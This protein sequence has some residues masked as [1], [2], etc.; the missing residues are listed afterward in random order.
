[1]QK[2][3]RPRAAHCLSASCAK[4][5]LRAERYYANARHAL[6]RSYIAY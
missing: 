4:S 1:M 5:P 2:T 6:Q 3:S